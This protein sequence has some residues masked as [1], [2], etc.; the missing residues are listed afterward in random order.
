MTRARRSFA[1]PG[2]RSSRHPNHGET[3]ARPPVLWLA[4]RPR[5]E[6]RHRRERRDEPDR[7]VSA[8]GRCTTGSRPTRG[9]CLG[10]AAGCFTSRA[11][12]PPIAV[13]HV[14]VAV[15]PPPPRMRSAIRAPCGHDLV[16][17]AGR[18]GHGSPAAQLDEFWNRPPERL[19]ARHGNARKAGGRGDES[20]GRVK[21]QIKRRV[22]FCRHMRHPGR[23]PG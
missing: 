13:S 22:L 2:H 11:P 1:N 4:I 9:R 5:G 20:E 16:G 14:G 15:C 17:E 23:D 10:A 3:R 6:G 18:F 21:R 12:S 7:F 19:V 8:P